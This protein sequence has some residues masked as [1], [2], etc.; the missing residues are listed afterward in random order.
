MRPSFRQFY[1]FMKHFKIKIVLAEMAAKQDSQH[2]SRK[3]VGKGS[4]KGPR[5]VKQRY[6]QI[7]S[8][9]SI[10]SCGK[11]LSHPA[12]LSHHMKLH[13]GDLQYVCWIKEHRS[14]GSEYFCAKACRN[15]G[16]WRCHARSH[17]IEGI[18]LQEFL[19]CY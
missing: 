9:C 2:R 11:V 7:P 17:G 10:A 6:V 5:N 16:N 8:K 4:G 18:V 13:K 12:H 1:F 3:A 14:D 19:F 15:K